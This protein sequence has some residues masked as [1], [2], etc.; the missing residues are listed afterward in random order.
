MQGVFKK[1]NRVP[2]YNRTLVLPSA[3][4]G[5]GFNGGVCQVLASIVPRP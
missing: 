4:A 2:L 5:L 1:I 3:P